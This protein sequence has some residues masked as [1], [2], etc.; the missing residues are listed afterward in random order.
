MKNV[1]IDEL[2]EFLTSDYIYLPY[3]KDDINIRNDK[4]VYKGDN[5]SSNVYSPVSGRVYGLSEISSIDG[6]KRVIVIENDFKDKEE[7][8]RISNKDIYKLNKDIVKNTLKINE[9]AI[10][11]KINR[12]SSYDKKD[13]F[14]LKDNVK[15]I[16]ETLNLID[17][18]YPSTKVKIIIDKK[19]VTSYQILF[20]Y[21]GTYPNIDIEF[22][23]K[24]NYKD[25]DIYNIIDIYNTLKNRVS[26]DFI[27]FTLIYKKMCFV[28]KCKKYT[29]LSE[30]LNYYEICPNK[31]VV[32]E[33][34]QIA[35]PHYLLDENIYLVSIV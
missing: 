6:I 12:R 25:Y 3:N 8:K 30:V 20:S 1:I 13:S 21:I 4:V 35:S 34:I 7:Y 27:Y 26:R 28:I 24:K 17:I 29:N 5:V 11:F 14:I 10:A 33:K 31:I 2:N 16:L 18:V 15:I 22:K 9:T 19:D 23:N 32:N